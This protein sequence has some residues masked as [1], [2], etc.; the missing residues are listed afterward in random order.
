MNK[1]TINLDSR[2]IMLI[3]A[4]LL[5]SGASAYIAG[6]SSFSLISVILIV[7]SVLIAIILAK[8]TAKSL[9]SSV[10][11]FIDDLSHTASNVALTANELTQSGNSL[12]EGTAEQAASIQETSATLEE[13]ASMIHQ[14]AQN[15]KEA[16]SLAKQ[17]TSAADDGNIQMKNLLDAM[18]ELKKSSAEVAKIIKVIDEIAFQTNILSLN[19]AVEA[20]RAG[21]A[22]KGFA[23]VAEEVRNLA[24]RSAQA[25]K[26]TAVIIESNIKLSEKSLSMSDVVRNAL[27]GIRIDTHKV[28]E[29]LEEISAASQE[30]EI[31]INQ[32]NK[33]ISQMEVVIQNT[34]STAQESSMSAKN[35][36]SY[37][38]K[39]K[40]I[41]ET[42]SAITGVAKNVKNTQYYNPSSFKDNKTEKTNRY[43]QSKN[44]KK[45][46]FKKDKSFE[47]NMV[48]E[49]ED[50]NPPI[51]EIEEKKPKLTGRA[52]VN[53]E[54]II[55]LDDF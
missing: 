24:Q 55:P 16:D 15:T 28:S 27:E 17:T 13:S 32:I 22:G 26:D 19:A 2:L 5:L 34:A 10:A 39:I 1:N 7:I 43:S 14:T 20:A 53:P 30:Q 12:A 45:P 44:I 36:E 52:K 18:E 21:D 42:L 4:T 50:K 33:A 11:S 3:V 48:K 6:K 41:V 40:I 9:S 25:A 29:L 51:A 47:K 46:D 54:D 31:G 49:I 8:L 37:S 23:V 38:D 35:L